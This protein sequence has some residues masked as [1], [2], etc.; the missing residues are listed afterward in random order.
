MDFGIID[1]LLITCSAF[2]K[3][4]ER[5]N[6]STVGHTSAVCGRQENL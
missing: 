3:Y 1:E 2:I 4:L 5:K 6:G